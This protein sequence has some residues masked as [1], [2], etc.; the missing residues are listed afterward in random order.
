MYEKPKVF[1]ESSSESEDDETHHCHGHKKKCYRHHGDKGHKHDDD[2][3][4]GAGKNS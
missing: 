3:A 1:G 2:Q 4:G